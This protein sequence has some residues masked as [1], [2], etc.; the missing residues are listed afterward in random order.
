VSLVLDSRFWGVSLLV[1]ALAPKLILT[2]EYEMSSTSRRQPFQCV[3]FSNIQQLGGLGGL[4]QSFKVL[5]RQVYCRLHHVLRVA[6]CVV[7]L[8]AERANRS[9]RPSVETR[10]Y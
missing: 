9:R 1:K 7:V 2:L 5:T 10:A 3:A 8:V 6:C 4:R